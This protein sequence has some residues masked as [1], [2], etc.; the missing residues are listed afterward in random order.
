M[1]SAEGGDCW[2]KIAP[3]VNSLSHPASAVGIIRYLMEQ[4]SG[5]AMFG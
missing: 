5:D 2:P 3:F 1:F 4:H